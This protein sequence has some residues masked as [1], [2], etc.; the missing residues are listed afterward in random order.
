MMI[1]FICVHASELKQRTVVQ[2]MIRTFFLF[3]ETE[4]RN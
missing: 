3:D 1:D 4:M 2:K